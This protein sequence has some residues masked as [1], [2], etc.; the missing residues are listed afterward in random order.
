VVDYVILACFEVAADD[1]IELLQRLLYF[2]FQLAP[3]LPFKLVERMLQ[4]V[5][6]AR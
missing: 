1:V 3:V 4:T 6:A 5:D 2:E